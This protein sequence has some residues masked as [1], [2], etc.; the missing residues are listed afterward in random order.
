MFSGRDMGVDLGTANTLVYVKGKGI[1]VREPSVVAIRTD[2][3]AIEAVGDQAK[4]MIGRTPGNIVAVR[5]MKDGVI[6]DF[7]TTATMLRYFI[8]QA[9]RNKSAWSGKPR[10]MISVPSGI[11][12][13]EK[14]AVEDAAI[15]AGAKHAQTIE[16]P[17]AAAIGAGLPV[18]EPTGSMVV[19]I[20][21]GTTEVAIISLGGIVTSRSIRVAGDEMDEAIIQYIKKT[22]NLMI[23]E[24]TAEELKITI[25]T[26]MA[27]D[28]QDEM[29]IRGRDLVTGLPKTLTITSTEISEALADT[30]RAI[31]DAVKVTLE[32]SPPELAADIM[33]RGI[34]L[35]GGGALLRNLSTLLSEE[36]GMPVIVAE[37]PL[38]CVAVGTGKALDNYDLYKR[39]SSL[40]RKA[41]SRA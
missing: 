8:R 26:A 37:N 36:T 7:Q 12:A 23:G 1:V 13:V 25:G 9:M 34:V 22:Y 18:G 31:I 6:A 14:R 20:G 32:K 11:T 17:M 28:T 40:A 29:D 16:E 35:T 3:G 24:R 15:E 33:D 39:R 4:Q 5:P 10:V 41:H 27:G 30:V 2:T 38:D 19:D 21:G